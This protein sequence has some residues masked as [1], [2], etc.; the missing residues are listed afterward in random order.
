MEAD[1]GNFETDQEITTKIHPINTIATHNVTNVVN[2][3]SSYLRIDIADY[4][5]RQLSQT[6]NSNT[7]LNDRSNKYSN[8]K[9]IRVF[10]T[11]AYGLQ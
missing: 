7:N 1:G 2:F 6:K 4:F 5:I 8:V 11:Y 10:Y 9:K 3:A